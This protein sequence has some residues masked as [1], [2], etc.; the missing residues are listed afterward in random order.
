MFEPISNSNQREAVRE[1]FNAIAVV[2]ALMGMLFS[3]TS[4]QSAVLLG[5]VIIGSGGAIAGVLR[6]TPHRLIRFVPQTVVND[7]S[8]KTDLPLAA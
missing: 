7:Y 3:A 2:A 6:R 8:A 1:V 4:G 5:A